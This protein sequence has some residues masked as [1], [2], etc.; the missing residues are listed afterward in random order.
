MIEVQAEIHLYESKCVR[1]GYVMDMATSL[2]DPEVNLPNP[3]DISLCLK[4]GLLS[5][6]DQNLKLRPPSDE[7]ITNLLKNKK[8]WDRICTAVAIIKKLSRQKDFR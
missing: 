4:C 3:G 8:E 5:I 1:C 2:E 6:F 7:E